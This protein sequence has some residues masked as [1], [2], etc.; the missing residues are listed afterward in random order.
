MLALPTETLHVG[1]D[2]Q[3]RHRQWPYFPPQLRDL[4]AEDGSE[5]VR[6]AGHDAIRSQETSETRR[7]LTEIARHVESLD[8]TAGSGQQFGEARLAPLGRADELDL[9]PAAITAAGR[10]LVLESVLNSR[11]QADHRGRAAREF[12]RS[13]GAR[14][15]ADGARR[16][17]DRT[18]CSKGPAMSRTI[19]PEPALDLLRDMGDVT[20]E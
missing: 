7:A 6:T 5:H 15:T 2:I 3:A 10:H 17:S 13:N 18:V 12:R 4:Y 8:R 14:P 19:I 11:F 16:L 9:D 1:R 20:F